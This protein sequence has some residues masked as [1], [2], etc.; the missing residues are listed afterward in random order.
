MAVERALKPALLEEPEVRA[1]LGNPSRDTFFRL[2][3]AGLLRGVN[4]GRGVRYSVRDLDE[5]VEKLQ[6]NP[7]LI[8]DV[9][10]N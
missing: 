8:R 10:G 1:Y 5:L 3:R 7:G 9:K 2:R 4:F 6:A